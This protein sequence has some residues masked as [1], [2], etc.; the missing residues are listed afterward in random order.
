M[1]RK[2]QV[3][4]ILTKGL[5]AGFLLQGKLAKL[6]PRQRVE[7]DGENTL[8]FPARRAF[9]GYADRRTIS[10][11]GR[12][13]GLNRSLVHSWGR[14]LW[15]SKE[16]GAL[17]HWLCHLLLLSTYG[18]AYLSTCPHVDT[19]NFLGRLSTRLKFLGAASVDNPM[20]ESRSLRKLVRRYPG[21]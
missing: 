4:C 7:I 20:G 2:Q 16:A 21:S 12:I 14:C 1:F 13:G 9:G 3:D 10:R 11:Y 6:L 19:L 5:R 17:R 18:H 15:G 8:P